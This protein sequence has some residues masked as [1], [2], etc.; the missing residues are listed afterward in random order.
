VVEGSVALRRLRLR[1]PAT[2]SVCAISLSPGTEAFWD[3]GA[4]AVLCLACGPAAMPSEY[5]VAGGSAAAEAE[6]RI[7]QRVKQAR[8]RYG[9]YAAAVAEQ[10][11]ADEIDRVL[12]VGKQWR[13][14]TRGVRRAR[15]W[16]PR[17]RAP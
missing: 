14:P 5:G 15:S 2:C 1:Y 7:D 12:A 9:D 17:D 16:R 6:R 3:R 11:A 13:K 4:K 8:R 10:V